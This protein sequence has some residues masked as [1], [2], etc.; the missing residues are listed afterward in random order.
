L[1]QNSTRETVPSAAVE[2]AAGIVIKSVI[3]AGHVL[4]AERVDSVGLAVHV[5]RDEGKAPFRE[6]EV[7]ALG[8]KDAR[9]DAIA[10]TAADRAIAKSAA[11]N[12]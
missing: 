11:P 12:P 4:N 9:A 5:R 6:E 8:A 10:M 7:G 1:R 3:P 2:I